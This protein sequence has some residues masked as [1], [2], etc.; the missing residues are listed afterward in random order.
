M[1]KEPT[2][3]E[4]MNTEPHIVLC[5]IPFWF[6]PLDSGNGVSV[7]YALHGWNQLVLYNDGV[8]SRTYG[9][10]SKHDE[11]IATWFE[12]LDNQKYVFKKAEE[13]KA[14]ILTKGE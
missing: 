7:M 2:M 5:E 14:S 4:I 9:E 12:N 11:E 3:E 1:N 13:F 8:I 6:Y 10:Y